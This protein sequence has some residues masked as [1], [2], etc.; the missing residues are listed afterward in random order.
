MNSLRALHKFPYDLF[1]TLIVEADQSTLKVV[2]KN[3]RGTTETAYSYAQVSSTTSQSRH[4][5]S[6]WQGPAKFLLFLALG[7]AFGGRSRN[8]YI[9]AGGFT[10]AALA[11]YVAS[12]RRFE[13][14]TFYLKNG[15]YLFALL[16]PEDAELAAHIVRR[17]DEENA[18]AGSGMERAT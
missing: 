16:L 8:W 18:R 9:A 2:Y 3:L 7:M 12:F 10:L 11:F 5:E 17:V 15:E 1:G 14:Q 6:G 13:W 4:G